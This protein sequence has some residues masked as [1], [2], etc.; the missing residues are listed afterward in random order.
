[1]IGIFKNLLSKLKKNQCDCIEP[2]FKPLE[3]TDNA[4]IKIKDQIGS[5]PQGIRTGFKVQVEYKP[6]RAFTKVGFDEYFSISTIFQYPIPITISE[7]DEIFLRGHLIDF[8]EEENAFFIY[9][10]IEI[11]AEDTPR[12]NIVRFHINR[13]IIH[14]ESPEKQYVFGKGMKTENAPP[15]IKSISSA[16]GFLSLYA[17]CNKIQIEFLPQEICLKNE[18]KMASILLDH[19]ERKGYPLYVQDGQAHEIY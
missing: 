6:D 16:K 13:Y 7:K 15:L 2:S 8:F 1:M 17:A 11:S 18:E 12:K 4:I 14:P 3:F 5:R 10:N 19:F 9:P